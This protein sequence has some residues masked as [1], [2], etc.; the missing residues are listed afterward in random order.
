MGFQGI[1]SRGY[2]KHYPWNP[3]SGA[4]IPSDLLSLGDLCAMQAGAV[5]RHPT[6]YFA[7]GNLVLKVGFVI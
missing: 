3:S 7:D 5:A 6:F 2:I 1:S 4:T